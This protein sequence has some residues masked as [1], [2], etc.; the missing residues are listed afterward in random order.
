MGLGSSAHTT[1]AWGG[2]DDATH[3]LARVAELAFKI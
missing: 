1:D 2:V 3:A